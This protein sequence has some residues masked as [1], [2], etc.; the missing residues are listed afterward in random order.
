MSPMKTFK[1]YD[2]FDG[3]PSDGVADVKVALHLFALDF[4]NH[5]TIFPIEEANPTNPI[6]FGNKSFI[7]Y[8]NIDLLY[9]LRKI[10]NFY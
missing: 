1:S 3:V 7:F 6:Y 10:H 4:D 2:C 5:S 8:C 9:W